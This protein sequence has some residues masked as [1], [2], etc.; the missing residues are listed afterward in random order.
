MSTTDDRPT[1]GA[2]VTQVDTLTA[3]LE[4]RQF[5]IDDL[6]AALNTAQEVS[7]KRQRLAERLF[8]EK[9]QA[10]KK[11]EE[12]EGRLQGQ[13]A[14]TEQLQRMCAAA[15]HDAAVLRLKLRDAQARLEEEMRLGALRLEVVREVH[16]PEPPAP[17][18][19]RW[20]A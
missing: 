6:Q 7:A 4:S 13:R 17:W 2:L 15:E 14:M 8:A 19:K 20:F 9:E 10:Q 18:W 3:R 11:V 12:I 16:A 5:V 1:Y